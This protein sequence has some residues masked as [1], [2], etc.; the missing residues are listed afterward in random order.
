MKNRPRLAPLE[1][2]AL[3]TIRKFAMLR[4]GEHVLVAA[5][6]GADSTALL[7]CLHDL[8]PIMNLKLTVAHFNHGIRGA[9]AIEDEEF[10]RRSSADLG[11]PFLS[12]TADLKA[13]AA[14][15]GRNL[16]ELAREARYA[17]L[18]RSA[19]AAGAG[20]IATGHNLNDQDDGSASRHRR[21]A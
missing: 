19:A 9:E 2:R 3:R 13:L 17:F 18:E 7:L 4:R 1:L 5:S 8:A 21:R 20:R 16:E 6:G 11:W 12:E 14:A 10:V 15:S